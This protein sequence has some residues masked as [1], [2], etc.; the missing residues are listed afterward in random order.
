LIQFITELL[1]ACDAFVGGEFSSLSVDV[2]KSRQ[3]N[4]VDRVT[5]DNQQTI[6]RDERELATPQPF[7]PLTQFAELLLSYNEGQQRLLLLNNSS[8]SHTTRDNNG[9][10]C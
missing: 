3:Q 6:V 9:C 10:C 1:G 7:R 4:V 5:V 8:R 2:F